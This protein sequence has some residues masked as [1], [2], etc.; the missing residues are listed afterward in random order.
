[1]KYT[2]R[3][4]EVFAAIARWESVSRA[5][6]ALAM[7]QSAASTSLAELERQF[8]CQL[9]DRIGKRLQLNALGRQLLPE[10]DALLGRAEE[11]QLLL[12]GHR[13]GGTLRLGATLTIGNYLAPILVAAFM[14]R[15]PESTVQLHVDNTERIV[16]QIARH[17]LD[18]GLIE[19]EP[20]HAQIDA[21]PWLEDELV[22]FCAPEHPFARQGTAVPEELGR[23]GWILR[24]PG[25][26]TRKAFERALAEFD[27]P[28][29]IRL[30]LEHT[31]AIKRAVESGLGIGC[32]S[33][34]ALRENFRRG[35]LVPVETPLLELRRQFSF[36]WHKQKYQTRGMQEFLALCR[37]A[38]HGHRR[39]DELDLTAM[40]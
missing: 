14:R 31:E 6:T 34:L 36:I 2:L 40:L 29:E 18:F 13:G 32:I 33:R 39:S 22:V 15:F 5:A 7:S 11:I 12:Q 24:E 10:V 35:G 38:S 28:I 23:E 1:M 21:E 4:L 25:S 30:E 37:E 16:E 8:D 20:Q 9:F 26:G 17:E 19:G 27:Q 3:Q